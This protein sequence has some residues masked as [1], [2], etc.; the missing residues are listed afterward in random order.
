MDRTQLFRIS[1]LEEKVPAH[2]LVSNTDLVIIQYGTEVSVPY[3]RCHHRG[4]LLGDGHIDGGNLICGVHGW[5]YRY[6]LITF[7]RPPTNWS[8]SFHVPVA[9]PI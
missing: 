1:E 5:D 4:A 7:W 8:R 9:M 2:A 6:D 3:G